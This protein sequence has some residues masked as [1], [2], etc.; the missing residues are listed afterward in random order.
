MSGNLPDPLPERYYLSWI[1]GESNWSVGIRLAKSLAA[2][3]RLPLT[4]IVPSKNHLDEALKR[5]NVITTRR[6]YPPHGTFVAAL[7]P[8]LRDM[9]R[10]FSEARHFFVVEHAAHDMRGWAA[11][12]GAYDLREQAVVPDDRPERVREIHEQVDYIGYNG[13]RSPPGSYS[14][15]GLLSELNQAGWLD[16]RGKSFL[17]GSLL[18][19]RSD[20]SLEDLRRMVDKINPPPGRY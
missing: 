8:D 3:A 10:A 20:S 11:T 7:Y 14:I 4:F 12:H 9:A 15:E 1:D 6:S 17:L 18:A 16:E 5:E 19:T 2:Q 13:Y